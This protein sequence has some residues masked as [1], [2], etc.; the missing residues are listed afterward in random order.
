MEGYYQHPGGAS[1]G[2]D[3]LLKELAGPTTACNSLDSVPL[4]QE[5]LREKRLAFLNRT[6]NKTE[7]CTSYTADTELTEE[8]QLQKAISMSMENS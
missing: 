3:D 6:V 8:E 5:E 2:A 1:S 4:S 7:P